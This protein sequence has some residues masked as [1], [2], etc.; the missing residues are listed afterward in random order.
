[1]GQGRPLIQ[2]PSLPC[3][4]RSVDVRRS[5]VAPGA[6]PEEAER[7]LN[8][9]K[10]ARF[11]VFPH[12]PTWPYP[13]A[14]A[15]CGEC[16]EENPWRARFCLACGA[17]LADRPSP[18]EERKVVSILFVDLVSFTAASDQTD[19]ED[20][21]AR[22]RPYHARAK[23]EIE[24]LGGTVEKFVG[25]AVMAAFG[26]PV[27]HEDD[28]E[29]AVRAGLRII[30]AIEELNRAQP[31]LGLSIRAAVNTGEAVVVLRANPASGEGFVTGDVV[32]TAARMQQAGPVG[33]LVVG[34]L[35]FETTRQVIEYE[36]LEPLSVKGKAEPLSMWLAKRPRRLPGVEADE[37]ARTP[38]IGRRHELTVL[39]EA[40]ARALRESS[41]Q[42]VTL[43]GEPGVGKSRIVAEFHA[44][45][46]EQPNP[47]VWR[48]G[49]CLPYGEG[50]TF[51]AL[52]QIIKA[53][54]GVLDSDSPKQTSAK[55]ASAVREV[56]QDESE[57]DWYQAKL[58]PLVGT[59]AAEAPVAFERS[60]SFA[61]W[62]R[63]LEAIA[64]KKP[65]VLVFEDLHWAD[66]PILEFVEH[67]VDWSTGV[68]LLVVCTARPELFE[69][70]P[71]WGGGKR[72]STTASL[73]PL[74]PEETT[75]LIVGLLSQA[76]LPAATLASLLDHAG[77]NPLYAEEFVRM[78]RDRAIL[79]RHGP[80]VAV[81]AGVEIPI[82][83]SIQALIAAR[84]DTLTPERKSILQAAA[85]VGN[86]FWAGAV[87]AISGIPVDSIEDSLHELAKKELVRRVRTTSVQGEDEYS[88][89]HVLVRD[90]AYQQIPRAA[91]AAKHQAAAEWIERIAGERVMDNAE[92][93]A[94]H[95]GQALEFGRAA[96]TDTNELEGQ[97]KRVLML[98]GERALW[99]DVGRAESCFRRALE[100]LPDTAPERANVIA[101][102]AEAAALAGRYPEAEAGYADA[103]AGL[104]AQ[105]DHR[106]AGEALVKLAAIVRDRGEAA[107]A[108]SL[109]AEAVDL[110]ERVPPGPELVLA[111]THLARYYHFTWPAEEAYK[112]ADK[113]IAMAAQLG[114]ENRSTR[115]RVF[116]GYTRFEL[117][118][119]GGLDDLN[120]ALRIALQVGLG[121]DTAGTYAALGD[122][123]WW[124]RGPAAGLD[125]Y[126]AGIDFTERRGMTYYAMYLKAESIWPMFDLGKWDALLQLTREIIEWDPASYQALLTL[127]YEAHV[128]LC[129]GDLATSESLRQAF[130]PRARQSA[131]P[132]VLIPALS[133]AAQ[134]ESARGN[135]PAAISLIEELE[136]ATRDRPLR[137]A[138]HL[139]DALRVCAAAGATALGKTLLER[140]GV[141][142]ARHLI[143]VH[144]ARAVLDEMHG[145][146]KTALVLH[147]EAADRWDRFGCVLEQGYALL[148]AGRCSLALENQQQATE[149]LKK[150]RRIF[151]SLDARPL[152]AEAERLLEQAATL[153]S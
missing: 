109:L 74:T 29:R 136:R 121:E 14:V 66:D 39:S 60:Q 56:I 26:A 42:L 117:G 125:V 101:K 90:V 55:L 146:R 112:W 16:G 142:A 31:E 94:H 123:V 111:Y 40:Y 95:Y 84:L 58:D 59:G 82:P 131:D 5:L 113:A 144:S 100:L 25:D 34:Q 104:R 118:E 103:I 7:H 27:T 70:R 86:V 2:A 135:F 12:R 19:P 28:A 93:L 48:L 10:T 79:E 52:G 21:R 45:L 78:L 96:G 98:A 22:L 38:F 75:R 114:I 119:A 4:K 116:R 20:V 23:Q 76:V 15:T 11:V 47:V 68:P 51:W 153:A 126:R 107:R 124:S 77:G 8:D 89:W 32:N 6:H 147:E 105:G 24:R 57:R 97:T 139:P 129:R 128:R 134:I 91:R 87:A 13:F 35:T 1:V 69:R 88:F 80:H 83:N 102:V 106:A 81:A 73:S 18:D 145:Q 110:L 108:R 140:T 62:R 141:S 36:K 33:T 44:F 143:S 50:I 151:E 148:G 99:L 137:R 152:A 37:D 49:R 64:T 3:P 9:T 63:F 149:H 132:Q 85:V 115:A 65:L 71:G 41:I 150:A 30:A 120:E 61:A 67:L 54:A 46:N 17:R 72:N 92:L 138:Q 53:Q 133:V 43:T 122:I 130:L 127:S